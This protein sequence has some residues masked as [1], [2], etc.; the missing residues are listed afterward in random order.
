MKILL[1]GAGAQGLVI[2]A[3]LAKSREVSEIKIADIDLKRAKSVADRLNSGKLITQRLDVSNA[4]EVVK[5]AKDMD[6]VINAISIKFNA[7][8]M[9]AAL[10]NGA[11]YEDMASQYI[12]DNS[13]FSVDQLRFDADWKKAE[14]TALIDMG[15]SPGL[16]DLIA[17]EVTDDLDRVNRIRVLLFYSIES[18]EIVSSWAPEIAWEDMSEQPVVFE[19]GKFKRVPPF[20]GEETY[21]FP[22]PIG[23]QTIVWHSHEEAILMPLFIGKG[24]KHVDF[25]M[26]GGFWSN[27]PMTATKAIVKLG[28]TNTKPIEIMGA[29]IAPRDILYALTPRTP[30]PEEMEK[31]IQ[32]GAISGSSG[33]ILLEIEGEKGGEEVHHTLSVEA[34]NI[35]EVQEKVPGASD[36][37]YMVGIPTALAAIKLGRGEIGTHGVIPPEGLE[38]NVR[39]ALLTELADRGI[40]VHERIEKRLA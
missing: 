24:L 34:P 9:D 11:Y 10:R 4:N 35:F 13:T 28:F 19:N 38:R 33:S 23:P 31:K 3:E 26:G 30:T 36:L 15:I 27:I 5:A 22:E 25:K 7:N 20:S 1:L 40:V 17:R 14:C 16:T 8:I 18:K 6:V 2:A 37:S 12:T 29:K 32:T 39:R 21:V